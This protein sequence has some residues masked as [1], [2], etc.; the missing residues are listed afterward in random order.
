MSRRIEARGSRSSTIAPAGQVE[1]S[2]LTSQRPPR[3]DCCV[4]Q[5]P[6]DR[7]RADLLVEIEVKV[8]C[9][10]QAEPLR[11]Y[12]S[13]VATERLSTRGID[14]QLLELPAQTI[15]AGCRVA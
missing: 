13:S 10:G 2:S 14:Q 3:D 9:P 11:G 4:G 15:G 6:R 12:R 8:R 7:D 5:R 1:S